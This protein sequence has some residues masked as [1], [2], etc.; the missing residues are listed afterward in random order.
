VDVT[1]VMR[2]N[3]IVVVRRHYEVHMY[4]VVLVSVFA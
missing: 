1:G 2:L 4:R 3:A